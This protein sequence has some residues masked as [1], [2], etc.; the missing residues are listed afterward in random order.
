MPFGKMNNDQKAERFIITLAVFLAL[1]LV[2]TYN[3][4]IAA[5]TKGAVLGLGLGVLLDGGL[6][7][8]IK[9]KNAARVILGFLL[10][11]PPAFSFAL[12]LSRAANVATIDLIRHAIIG[13]FG[14]CLL[15]WRP[16]RAYTQ[17]PREG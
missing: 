9:R 4:A 5:G 2:L 10:M 16:I 17:K 7:W 1:S 13:I 6:C 11:L 15:A 8:L 12:V 14:L 3:E